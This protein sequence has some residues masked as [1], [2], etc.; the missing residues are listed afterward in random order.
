LASTIVLAFLVDTVLEWLD[1]HYQLF[2]QRLPSRRRLFNDIYTLTSYPYFDS[3]NAL[4]M[5]MLQSF[6]PG[7]SSTAS[8]RVDWPK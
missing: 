5:F 7:F 3:C 4:M 8:Y 2:R 6:E 1:D